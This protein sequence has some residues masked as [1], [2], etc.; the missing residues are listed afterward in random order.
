MVSSITVKVN[1]DTTKALAALQRICWDAVSQT[2]VAIE[3]DIKGAGPHAQ[4]ALRDSQGRYVP[5]APGE[6]PRPRTGNLR[7]SYHVTLDEPAL[8]AKVGSDPAIAPYAVFLELGTRRMEARP[9]L[10]PAMEYQA[11]RLADR[12]AKGLRSL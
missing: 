1:V 11:P 3:Q 7:R 9:H 4:P 10:V 12:V 5:S 2:A 8:T 6:P